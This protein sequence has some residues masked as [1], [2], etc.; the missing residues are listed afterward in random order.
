MHKRYQT[1]TTGE[2]VYDQIECIV[3]IIKQSLKSGRFNNIYEKGLL[4]RYKTIVIPLTETHFPC[5]QSQCQKIEKRTL[6]FI[7]YRCFL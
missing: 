4:N 7:S 2:V 1:R 3:R 6:P 5:E